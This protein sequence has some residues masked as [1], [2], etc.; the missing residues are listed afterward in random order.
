MEKSA[1]KCCKPLFCLLVCA[2]LFA[3]MCSSVC[4]SAGLP[5]RL[6]INYR[7]EDVSISEA[8]FRIYRI[9]DL[10][11]QGELVYTDAFADLDLS[12]EELQ[13][14]QQMLYARVE[15]QALEPEKILTTD[16]Y[17]DAS[18]AAFTTGAFLLICEPAAVDDYVYYADQQVI[19]LE[20]GTLTVHPKSTRLPVGV[21]LISIQTTKFWDDRGY[22]NKRPRQI[23]VRL[24]K[25]GKTFSTVV[26]SEA[27]GWSYTWNDLLPNARWS[28]EEDV[29][30]GY[31][32]S[33]EQSDHVFT[34]TNHYKDIPQTGQI[35]WPVLVALG[36]GLVLIMIGL[37]FRRS[38]HN[39][40]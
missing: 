11:T 36:V 10:N 24:L 7:Y 21:R 14:Q 6:V 32:A 16:S 2:V 33:V 13:H 38:G 19:F 9:A 31:V 30:K 1:I 5:C 29:P 39:E 3:L 28:V 18:A 23:S 34:L 25:D 27:N 35:W 22:E 12:K 40:T 17:G 15:A 26:L 37:I 8:V 20:K 4:A